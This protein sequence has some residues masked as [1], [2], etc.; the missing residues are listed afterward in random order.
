MKTGQFQATIELSPAEV[1]QAV[2]EYVNRNIT[3]GI[4]VPEQVYLDATIHFDQF[5]RGPGSPVLSKA[6]V[7][8]E[9]Q[10]D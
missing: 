9:L 6:R 3:T 5:D 2:A 7:K 4:A 10:K 1:K 8:V